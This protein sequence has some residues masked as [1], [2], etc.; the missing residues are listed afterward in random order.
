MLH[1]KQN[2]NLNI[3]KCLMTRDTQHSHWTLMTLPS[4]T[5]SSTSSPS[6]AICIL[7]HYLKICF[8]LV[9]SEKKIKYYLNWPWW[10]DSWHFL[11]LKNGI[12]FP[13]CTLVSESSELELASG[14][15]LLLSRGIIPWVFLL[16]PIKET[17][18]SLK[19][20]SSKP[21]QIYSLKDWH[22][23]IALTDVQ[24]LQGPKL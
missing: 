1:G 21:I 8:W 16:S 4:C 3:P 12:F 11:N 2:D 14:H 13:C 23:L 18:F 19:S 17:V 10:Y 22:S 6:V 7:I 24:S 20:Y 15:D 5:P 9:Y